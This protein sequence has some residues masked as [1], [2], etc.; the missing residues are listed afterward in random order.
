MPCAELQL[1]QGNLPA[2]PAAFLLCYLLFSPPPPPP[3]VSEAA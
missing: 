3:R 1:R 2:F